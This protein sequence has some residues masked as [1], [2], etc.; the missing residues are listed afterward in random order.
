MTRLEYAFSITP[1]PFTETGQL[2][3]HVPYMDIALPSFYDKWSS[4]PLSLT[5]PLGKAAA[6]PSAAAAPAPAVA[7]QGKGGRQGGGAKP[8]AALSP[9]AK[10]APAPVKLPPVVLAVGKPFPAAI[11]E[12]RRCKVTPGTASSEDP[13]MLNIEVTGSPVCRHFLFT[14]RCKLLP[15][16]T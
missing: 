4:T 1:P 3:P 9:N 7:K 10:P 11:V 13:T 12:F 5:T 16:C 14:S 15:H 6:A 8:A 2:D